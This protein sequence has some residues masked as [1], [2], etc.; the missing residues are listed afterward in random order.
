MARPSPQTERLVDTLELL[1]AVPVEGRTLA[2]I[3]RHLAVDKATCYPMLTELTKLGWLV[4]HPRRK[5]FHLGPSLVALGRAAAR[6]L[7]IVDLARPRLQQ[8]ADDLAIAATLTMPSGDALVIAD[9]IH[10]VGRRS[11]TYQLRAGDRIDFRPPH[12]AALVA[13]SAPAV[14]ERWIRRGAP[15]ASPGDA[16]ALNHAL[17]A[18]RASGFA[19]Q[20]QRNPHGVH[21]RSP[22]PAV[23]GSLRARSIDLRLGDWIRDKQLVNDLR[24]RDEVWPISVSA[25]IFDADAHGIALVSTLDQPRPTTAEEVERIGREVLNASIDVTQT[26]HGRVPPS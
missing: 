7:D 16:E 13:W 20:E 15:D 23:G 12:G 18:I 19:V 2:D 14:V 11:R 26:I 21:D 5:T 1:A 3:A 6:S 17:T 10:P 24:D 9:L 8:L 25:P 22:L 4:R